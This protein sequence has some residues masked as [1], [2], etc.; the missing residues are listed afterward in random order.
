[1]NVVCGATWRE[2]VEEPK[3]LLAGRR[4]EFGCIASWEPRLLGAVDGLACVCPYFKDAVHERRERGMLPE[5]PARQR[6]S[7]RRLELRLEFHRHQR[8]EADCRG[9]DR[10]LDCGRLDFEQLP[11]RTPDVSFDSRAP[12]SLLDRVGRGI[13]SCIA[14]RALG[15]ELR[16]RNGCK[17]PVQQSFTTRIALDLAARGLRDRARRDQCDSV[18]AHVVLFGHVAPDGV[19]DRL[20]VVIAIALERLREDGDLLVTVD[21][22]AEGSAAAWSDCRVR[23]FH[24]QLEVV[25]VQIAPTENDHVLQSAGYEQLAVAHEPKVAAAEEPRAVPSGY[26]RLECLRAFGRTLPVAAC[27]ARPADP[28]LTDRL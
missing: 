21:I 6:E 3:P 28:D 10:Q 9:G 22:E 2:P 7:E 8:I 5:Q 4:A 18:H 16:D 12:H 19:E 25:R 14:L 11:R 13:E 27:D 23:R 24:R 20:A 15:I 26:E 1:M 17:R